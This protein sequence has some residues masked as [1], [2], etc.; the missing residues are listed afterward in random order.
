MDLVHLTASADD[1]YTRIEVLDGNLQPV[2]HGGGLGEVSVQLPPGAYA[3]RFQIG[4]DH[5]QRV[6]ILAPGAP[7]THVRLD[8]A[9][10]PRFASS[11]PVRKTRTT[12]ETHRGPA[13]QL[14]QSPPEAPCAGE[15]AAADLGHLL[16]FTRDLQESR[17]NDPSA[18]LSLHRLNGER[19]VD[20]A[21]CGQHDAGAR[22]AGAHLALPAG[23]WRLRLTPQ[24]HQPQRFVEQVIWLIP[25]WQTQ[26][27]LLAGGRGE[28]E[29]DRRVQLDTASV[30]MARA[31]QGFDPERPDLRWAESALRALR[32]AGNIP[33]ATRTEMLWAKFENPM[34]GL[35]A[36]LLHLRRKA[37]DPLLLR[38]V[39]NHLRA[40]VGNLPD[41]LALG[42]GL[43]RRDEATRQD[44]D[45]MHWLQQPTHLATPPML[46][47]S[48][49]LLLQAS[50]LQ[51]ALL[52]PQALASRAAQALTTGGPWFCWR[53]EPPP[54]PADDSVDAEA[55]EP[56]DSLGLSGLV[57]RFLKSELVEG[58]AA[59][60]LNL[61]LPAL[62]LVFERH[63]IGRSLLQAPR[64]TPLERRVAQYVDPL[65]DAQ[66]RALVQDDPA[67]LADL[68][69]GLKAR[70]STG[71]G[72]VQSLKVPAATALAAVGRLMRK[73]TLEPVVPHS[74]MLNSFV[75]QQSHDHPV[76]QAALRSLEP[77]PSRLRHLP[78]N[79][80]VPLLAIVFL[81]YRGSPSVSGMADPPADPVPDLAATLQA[82]ADSRYGVVDLEA[83]PGPA[84]TTEAAAPDAATL[85]AER[86]RARSLLVA[87][88][89]AEAQAGQLDLPPGWPAQVLPERPPRVRRDDNTER[90]QLLP[91]PA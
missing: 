54:A 52:P 70:G 12:R 83:A 11:A 18:G 17:P 90:L 20:L 22:W 69:A 36:G 57:K 74:L 16:L 68:R 38:E 34:L 5:V 10:T 4:G 84:P 33:G 21:Q 24:D 72:L 14:S 28:T 32:Q 73:L 64:Y 19:L 79:T 55:P 6:A 40:L 63:P 25:G 61:A 2:P 91:R 58:V 29:A 65:V 89:K 47:A 41:V 80:V 31:G 88:I 75:V 53:G 8:D 50:A 82:L 60:S 30:L 35:Y 85:Q 13:Q 48:W 59:G 87:R 26:V 81:C 1:E 66:L 27:F 39:V 76:L 9:D 67:A 46:R 77:L 44:S 3:V 7:P 49:D 62:E 42:H 51:P 23:A 56:G 71:E 86:D 15:A 78:S 43:A 37:I 45:F